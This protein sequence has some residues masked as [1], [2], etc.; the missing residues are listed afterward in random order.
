MVVLR[1][2]VA[3]TREVDIARTL[4]I[5]ARTARRLID[6]TMRR[7]TEQIRDKDWRTATARP[8]RGGHPARLHRRGWLAEWWVRMSWA[9]CWAWRVRIGPIHITVR[10]IP[11]PDRQP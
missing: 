6:R 7:L 10:D 8:G 1:M 11:A 2:L 9:A 5:S 3:G 4:G